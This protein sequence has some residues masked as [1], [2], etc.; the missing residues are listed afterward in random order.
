MGTGMSLAMTNLGERL[1]LQG[2]GKDCAGGSSDY[3]GADEIGKKMASLSYL[4]F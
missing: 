2:A 4:V 3:G 1:G